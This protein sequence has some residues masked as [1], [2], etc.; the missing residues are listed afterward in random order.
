M[1]REVG[2]SYCIRCSSTL[3]ADGGQQRGAGLAIQ[4]VCAAVHPPPL[5]NNAC[6]A[7]AVHGSTQ[8]VNWQY[9]VRKT[10]ETAVHVGLNE[11]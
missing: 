7:Q 2:P 1:Q 8:A 6:S 5:L 4:P 3:T 9:T 11:L 10:A